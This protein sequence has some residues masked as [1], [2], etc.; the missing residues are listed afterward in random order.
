VASNGYSIVMI[1][2]NTL[3]MIIKSKNILAVLV[4]SILMIN[5]SSLNA[6]IGASQQQQSAKDNP[7]QHIII[8]MQENHTFDNYFGTYPGANG[9][10][11]NVCMPLDPDHANHDCIKP[12]LTTDVSPADMA[13]GYLSSKIAKHNGKMDG[14]MLAESEDNNT[15]SYYDN[16]TIPY[17]WNL[18][19]HYVLADN[20]FS[21]ALSYSLPNHWYAIAGQAPTASMYYAM[22]QKPETATPNENRIAK[23]YLREANHINTIADLLVDRS[24]NTTSAT[25]IPSSIT[26]KYYYHNITEGYK[27]AIGD[28]DAYDYWNPFLAKASSY[29]EKY[30]SH[31]VTRDH[32]FSDLRHGALP[33]VSWVIPSD[34]QSEHP[35]HDITRGMNWVA[36]VIESIMESPYWNSTA[37]IVT[38]DDYGGFYD[39]VPPPSIDKYG[40]GFRMPAIIISPY[41]KSGYIDHTQYQFE[42]ILKF[43][44]WRFNMPPLTDRDR[45]A[46]NLINAFDFNQKP[47]PP[48]IIELSPEQ[49]SLVK[50][51]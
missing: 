49:L 17:Y 11:K 25:A 50:I 27:D 47:N 16:K 29:T 42:S 32:I 13:H 8:I 3:K 21:S 14:F 1:G 7:I 28:G 40:L 51:K 18:A 37:I 10:P 44:E 33:Q 34:N 26:W 41:A 15:M 5:V 38:W 43:I 6:E 45:N 4:L 19:K 22:T 46:N 35:P 23:E 9:I 30:S 24:F 31:F 20:F 39:H 48:Y 2:K 36:Y 12:F